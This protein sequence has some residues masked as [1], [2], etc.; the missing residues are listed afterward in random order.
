MGKSQVYDFTPP[1]LLSIGFIIGMSAYL[2]LL[3]IQSSRER[4][5]AIVDT[6]TKE[7]AWK[8]CVLYVEEQLH[9]P[10]HNVQEYTLDRVTKLIE[11]DHYG[12]EVLYTD[13]HIYECD[14]ARRVDGEWFLKSLYVK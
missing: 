12:V 9:V 13:G 5:E 7:S 4:S 3:F 6:T 14:L 8:A 10:R 1:L 2:G 11:K